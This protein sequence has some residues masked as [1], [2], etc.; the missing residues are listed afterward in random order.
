[1]VSVGTLSA[2]APLRVS[3]PALA[4]IAPVL[5]GDEIVVVPPLMV[6]PVTL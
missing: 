5:V 2:E 1:M 6:W 3:V 4:V